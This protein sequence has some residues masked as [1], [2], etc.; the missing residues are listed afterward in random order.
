MKDIFKYYKNQEPATLQDLQEEIKQIKTQIDEIKFF[1]QNIDVRISNIEHQKEV[2]TSETNEEL[3]TFVHNMTVVQKQ[4]WYTQITLKINHD[5]QST[6]I[7]LID[8]GADLNCIQEGLIPT[9]Y[10][11]KTSQ[12]ISTASN[13]PLKVHYKIPQ[14][15]ICKNGICI[16]TSFLLVKNI[17]H[18]IVL[19]TPF[20]TQLY[21]F[22]IDSQGLKTK[23]NNQEI[24]FE[25]IKGIKVK[26]INQVQDFINLFQQK[27]QHVKFLK[28]EIQYKKTEENLKSKQIQDRIKQIQQQIENNLC[29]SIPNAFW[30]RKQHMVYLPYEIFFNEKQIP[31][32]ARPI[33]MSPEL[34]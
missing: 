4:R 29:S 32:K 27:Q 25:F 15:H 13:D 22:S 10:F 20:L 31:T 8:S 18:Q 14:G 34:L 23:N 19:G 2:L 26:E 11:V 28:R 17:S 21:P 1:T 5:Y 9:V 16:K 6:F 12:K 7:A 30:N 24:L 3:E 33:Q